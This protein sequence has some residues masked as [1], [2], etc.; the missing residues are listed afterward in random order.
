[1]L[2]SA[3]SVGN[4]AIGMARAKRLASLTKSAEVIPLPH[5]RP[6]RRSAVDAFVGQRLREARLLAG[7]SQ[8]ELGSSVGVTF[9]AVQK[10]ESGENRL[11]ASRLLAAAK[12]LGKPVSFFFDELTEGE[13]AGDPTALTA[14]EIRLLRYYRSIGSDDMRNW[15]LKLAKNLGEPGAGAGGAKTA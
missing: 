4:E 1:M 14:K 11:S 7:L 9:Q 2:F 13:P 3:V 6:R 10:Y 8:T 5:G 15:L 12:L